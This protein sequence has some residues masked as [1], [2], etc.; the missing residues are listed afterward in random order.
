MMM[1]LNRYN[2]RTYFLGA[3][4]PWTIHPLG[5]ASHEMLS[6]AGAWEAEGQQ[7]KPVE[8]AA[9]E[10]G[11]FGGKMTVNMAQAVVTAAEPAA[12]TAEPAATTA[13]PADQAGSAMQD[14]SQWCNE[15]HMI[16]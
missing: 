7:R 12:T 14:G 9:E 10:E 13:L 11:G 5:D 15:D 8:G 3:Y 1:P 16:G 4:I 6:P 2:P